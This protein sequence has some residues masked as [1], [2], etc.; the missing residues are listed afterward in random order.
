MLVLLLFCYNM[1]EHF[2]MLHC[3]LTFFVKHYFIN[4]G[5]HGFMNAKCYN[6]M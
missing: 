4:G 2:E 3:I 1:V 6:M 5:Q